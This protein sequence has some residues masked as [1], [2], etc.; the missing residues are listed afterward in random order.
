[1]SDKDQVFKTEHGTVTSHADGTATFQVPH[2]SG[3]L[4]ADG[5]ATVK[6]HGATVETGEDGTRI[7]LS[8]LTKVAIDNII[9]VQSHTIQHGAAATSHHVVFRGGG[10][11]RFSFRHAD[12]KI[13]EFRG[14]GLSI[15]VSPEG[16][17][18]LMKVNAGNDPR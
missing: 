14:T 16:V 11:L 2:G 18:T 8:V 3:T 6:A 4:H 12:G 13:L 7:N 1:M 10:E 17:V 15:G 9:D 5:T